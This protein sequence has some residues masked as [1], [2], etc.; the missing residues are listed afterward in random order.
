VASSQDLFDDFVDL[1]WVLPD[2]ELGH[3]VPSF[4]TRGYSPSTSDGIHSFTVTGNPL[5][6]SQFDKHVRAVAFHEGRLYP[7]DLQIRWVRILRSPVYGSYQFIPKTW[8]QTC[9]RNPGEEAFLEK[10]TSVFVDIHRKDI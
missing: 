1:Q 2:Q 4:G 3:V 9:S 10:G 8:N 7:G 5:V 6:G